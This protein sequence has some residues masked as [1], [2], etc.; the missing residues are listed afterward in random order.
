[1]RRDCP[2]LEVMSAQHNVAA[3]SSVG[4]GRVGCPRGAQITT[5]LLCAPVFVVS[6]PRQPA[7]HLLCALLRLHGIKAAASHSTLLSPSHLK[8]AACA[9]ERVCCHTTHAARPHFT[10]RAHALVAS[11]QPLAVFVQPSVLDCRSAVAWAHNP[12]QGAA[13]LQMDMHGRKVSCCWRSSL[14]AA[15]ASCMLVAGRGCGATRQH[16]GTGDEVGLFPK[17]QPNLGTCGLGRI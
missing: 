9:S 5:R 8:A 7:P 11:P 3:A 15:G 13:L 17:R 12:R 14:T 1:M 2:V 16:Q 6:S 10:R 4:A